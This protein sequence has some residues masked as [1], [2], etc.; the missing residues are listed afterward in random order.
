MSRFLYRANAL[1]LGGRLSRPDAAP[2]LSQA[3]VVLPIDG[4]R[5]Q[6]ESGPFRH[7]ALVAFERA[8]AQVVG[9][10]PKPDGPYETLSQVTV[11]GLNVQDMVTADRLVAR[12][13]SRHPGAGEPR[14]IPLG[15]TF[16]N[17]R[18]AGRPVHYDDL[19]SLFTTRGTFSS[20]RDGYAKDEAFQKLARSAF[21][22]GGCPDPL[23]AD[24]PVEVRERAEW[25]A[26]NASA[27][28]PLS[29]GTAQ[30]AIV[31]NVRVEGLETYGN[32]V[33]VPGFGRVYLG[34]LLIQ[35]DSRR[36][37]MLRIDLGCPEEGTIVV[38]AAE[39]NGH[40]YP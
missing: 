7:G 22:W 27:Y 19:T 32:C 14:I 26:K 21:W 1:A 17:L 29:H 35:E 38:D 15:S 37:T 8:W 9:S 24:A 2:I 6:V 5:G 10:R 25:L 33:A 30:A 28:P 3:S 11:E 13:V 39:T 31:A 36:L 4:G 16:E 23:P 20:V 34:E 40:T 18:I 12:L